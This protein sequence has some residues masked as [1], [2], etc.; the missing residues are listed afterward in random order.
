[1]L[2]TALLSVPQFDT[3]SCMSADGPTDEE[4]INSLITGSEGQSQLS[5]ETLKVLL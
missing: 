4:G 2:Q 1:M 3:Q 5:G